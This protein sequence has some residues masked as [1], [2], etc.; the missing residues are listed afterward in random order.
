MRQ[1]S[2]TADYRHAEVRKLI[3]LQ[4]EE[5]IAELEMRLADLK[6]RL[7]AHSIPATMLIEM[8]DIEDELERLR[9]ATRKEGT[10]GFGLRG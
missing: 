6:A 4:L 1:Q 9:K 8:E 7:P 2:V 10:P 5:R 3:K